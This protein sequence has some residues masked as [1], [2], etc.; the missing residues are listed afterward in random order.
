M[1]YRDYYQVLGVKKGASE[2]EIKSAFRRLAQ[3][4]HPDKNPGDKRSEDKFKEINEAYEVLGD[5]QKRAKYD[6]LGASY[7]QWERAGQPGGGFDFSQ[8]A[9]GGGA[10]NSQDLNDLFGEGGFSDFFYNLFGGAGVGRRGAATRTSPRASTWSLRGN[11]MEQAIEISLEEAY[12]GTKR[13][14][15]KGER[16]LEVN[17]PAGAKT[18]TK[19]RLAGA[20]GAGQTPGDLFVVITVRPHPQFRR[21]GDDLNVE[22]PIDLY[23]A[24]L[25]G[26]ARVP[27]LAGEVRLTVTPEAQSGKTFRLSGRGMPKL[28]QASE[29]GDLYAHLQVRLPTHLSER[30]KQLFAE[31]AALRGRRD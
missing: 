9:S 12:R 3:Q 20:G 21:E 18:G 31:L 10:R 8:W 26:E 5:P 6:R 27:T 15:Q 11:D 24:V 4:Y 22:V 23:T 2:K 19:V 17:V 25:G 1:N 16:R 30:E 29:H 13:T 28:R 14:L 7:A